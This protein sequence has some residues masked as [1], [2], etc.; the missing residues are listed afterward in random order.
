MPGTKQAPPRPD[1]E[2]VAV[3][4][5][6]L[7]GER[8]VQSERVRRFGPVV[9]GEPES[10]LARSVVRREQRVPDPVA[11]G[12]VGHREEPDLVAARFARPGGKVVLL[13]HEGE[14]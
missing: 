11:D 14:G 5:E 3:R 13:A 9:P 4:S 6:L 7:E 8:P 1:L 10:G 2:A 12:A